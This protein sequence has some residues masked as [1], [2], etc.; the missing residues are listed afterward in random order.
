VIDST[1]KTSSAEKPGEPL[2]A[3]LYSLPEAN[4]TMRLETQWVVVVFLCTLNSVAQQPANGASGLAADRPSSTGTVT[5]H[6]YLDDTKGPAR[7]AKV[8]LQPTDAL[9]S[10]APHNRSSGQSDSRVTI[11][12]ETSFDGSFS[13]SHVANGAYY[14]IAS[15][16]GYLSPL[17]EA[18]SPYDTQQSSGPAEAKAKERVVETIPRVTVESDQPARAEVTLERGCAISGNISYDDGNPAIGLRVAVL[19]RTLREGKET[20]IPF[21]SPGTPFG[22]IRTDDRGNY[23]ISGLP[24][25]KYIVQVALDSSQGIMYVSSNG[26]SSATGSNNTTQLIIYSGNTPR[27]KDA[28]PFSVGLREERTGEDIR[29]PL[30]KLHRVSGFIVSAHDGHTINSEAVVLY[31]TDDQSFGGSANSTENNPGF[32]LNFVFD[33]EYMLSSPMSADVSYQLLPQPIGSMSPPLY[34][35]HPLHLYGS[36]AIP[37]HV[38]SDMDGVTIAVPEPTAKEAQIL[39]DIYKQQGEQT[40]SPQ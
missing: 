15:Y 30:S 28:A 39:K 27:L 13:F 35:S 14:V 4:T 21:N 7:K 34:D 29:I 11:E 1:A 17:A 24:D 31:S 19:A 2:L 40:P 10:N 33:G 20:W 32:T 8:S 12:I 25:Q 23:R 5:G 9:Q 37:L 36:A 22:M 38:Y 18:R 6:V 16:P 26:A 3:L